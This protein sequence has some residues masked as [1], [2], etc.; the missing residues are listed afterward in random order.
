MLVL[1]MQFSRNEGAGSSSGV[2][3]QADLGHH[4]RSV[5]G[6][7]VGPATVRWPGRTPSEQKRGTRLRVINSVSS[8]IRSWRT[9]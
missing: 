2:V 1:A 5:A 6:T 3:G 8:S 9:P 4:D 7:E